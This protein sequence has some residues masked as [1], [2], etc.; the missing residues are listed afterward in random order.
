MAALLLTY[1]TFFLSCVSSKIDMA[2]EIQ[3]LNEQSRI[4]HDVE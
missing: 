3:T 1:K 2:S 4:L